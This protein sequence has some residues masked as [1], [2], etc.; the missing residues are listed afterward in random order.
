MLVDALSSQRHLLQPLPQVSDGLQEVFQLCSLL[1][2]SVI[3]R[4]IYKLCELFFW[5]RFHVK[6]NRNN[7]V[8]LVHAGRSEQTHTVPFK[9]HLL[10]LP[11]VGRWRRQ[12]PGVQCLICQYTSIDL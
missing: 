5:P 9:H 2:E 11:G 1:Q 10:A 12:D 8:T 6:Q 7:C 4:S 3:S